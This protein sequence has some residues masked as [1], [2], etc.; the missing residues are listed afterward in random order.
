MAGRPRKIRLSWYPEEPDWWDDPR[1]RSVRMKY[2]YLS[3]VVYKSLHDMMA[4]TNGYFVFYRDERERADVVAWLQGR[5]TGPGLPGPDKI[6]S[7][8]RELVACGFLDGDLFRRGVLTSRWAQACFY[9]GTAKRKNVQVE[10]DIWLLTRQEMEEISTSSSVLQFF[11]SDG[12]YAI[13]DVNNRISDGRNTTEDRIG[14]K[15]RLDDRRG[16]EKRENPAE[17]DDSLSL[18]RER[19]FEIFGRMPNGA[20]Q[21]AIQ[22]LLESGVEISAMESVLDSLQDRQIEA[23]EPYVYSA[24][25]RYIAAQAARKTPED[26]KD[27]PLEQWEKEWLEDIKKRREQDK[28]LLG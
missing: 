18:Y 8:I 11:I 28:A 16:K 1:W 9:R 21:K 3:Y 20:N 6:E 5:L 12:N 26:D 14:D 2:G 17:P 23:P 22:N 19:F 10:P 7:V 24:I 4:L 13:N 27:R 25:K 15:I